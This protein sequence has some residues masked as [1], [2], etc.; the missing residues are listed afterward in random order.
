M[1]LDRESSKNLAEYQGKYRDRSLI[2][3]Y[4]NRRFFQ[5]IDS[6]VGTLPHSSLL[7]AGCG[8]GLIL[9]RLA[10]NGHASYTGVDLD[11]ARVA[12]A[13]E[14]SVSKLLILDRSQCGTSRLV[15]FGWIY[16]KAKKN[17]VNNKENVLTIAKA[18]C[19]IKNVTGAIC[20]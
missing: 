16:Y 20:K 14:N 4:A 2:L 9:K 3:R 18:D 15:G 17:P 11:P 12:L 10:T 8:E 13:H 19:L 1:S 6:L 7:D 5:T